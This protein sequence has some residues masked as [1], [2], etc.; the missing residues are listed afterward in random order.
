MQEV[1]DHSIR[2]EQFCAVEMKGREKNVYRCVKYIFG[3]SKGYHIPVEI[4]G[5]GGVLHHHAVQVRFKS[6]EQLNF[7]NFR[8]RSF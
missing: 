5:G 4:K 1:L 7:C 6:D 8:L 3:L 2:L